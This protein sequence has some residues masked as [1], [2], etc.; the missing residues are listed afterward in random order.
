MVTEIKVDNFEAETV[1]EALIKDKI[2]EALLKRGI[3]VD[4]SVSFQTLNDKKQII[5]NSSTFQTYPVIF[6]SIEIADFGSS[7]KFYVSDENGVEVRFAK[8]RV[9]IHL[10]YKHFDM[11][12]NGC[13]L[14][15]IKGEFPLELP[16]LF[17]V[18]ID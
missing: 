4:L 7:V 18:V 11:G 6:K 13:K 16:T 8:F 3:I 2:Q 15:D 12:S 5:V 10:A 9:A 14:F 17:N 1:V